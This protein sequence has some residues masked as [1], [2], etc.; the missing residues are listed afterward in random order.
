MHVGWH[1]LVLAFPGGHDG[2]I[3]GVACLVVE[4]VH[5]A[6]QSTHVQTLHQFM[7]C[8]YAGMLVGGDCCGRR[9]RVESN[10]V[11]IEVESNN[12]VLMSTAS[13]NWE[14]AGVIREQ[15]VER[16]FKEVE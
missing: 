12:N 5:R 13:M 15:F 1:Q 8:L 7:V 9:Q 10:G 3:I 4:D 16:E 14:A 2:I 6:S 11:G